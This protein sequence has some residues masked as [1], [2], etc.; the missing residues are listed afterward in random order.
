MKVK[1]TKEGCW[2]KGQFIPLWGGA[3]QQHQ[4]G[5]LPGCAARIVKDS[6]MR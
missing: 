2:Y 3:L 6:E 5:V 1:E 4:S